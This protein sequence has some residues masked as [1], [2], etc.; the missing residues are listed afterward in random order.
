MAAG[1]CTAQAIA[2]AA[3]AVGGAS[4][5]QAAPCDLRSAACGKLPAAFARPR[6]P[7]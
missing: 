3:A 1:I 4:V 2:Q 5:V 6:G 7:A